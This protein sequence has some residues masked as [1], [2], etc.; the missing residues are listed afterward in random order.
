MAGLVSSA[1]GPTICVELR[2]SDRLPLAKADRNQ[3]E[4]A[5]LNLAVNA[6]DAMDGSG[7]LTISAAANPVEP[8]HPAGLRPGLYIRLCVSD[9][10]KGM[11]E[12]TRIRAVEPFFST[13]GVGKGTGLGLSMAYGLASQLGGALTIESE[14]GAGAHVAIWLPQS[15]E[16]LASDDSCHTRGDSKDETGVV[17]LVDDDTQSRTVIAEMLT[18]LGFQVH[19][20]SAPEAALSAIRA[21][22]NPDILVTD[23]L[24]PGM[25]GLELASTV[26]AIIPDA[27]TLVI[28]GFAEVESIDASEHWLAK[29]FVQRDLA[30]ALAAIRT[31]PKAAH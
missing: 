17:L 6:R 30:K 10:G 15:V 28:S 21:G 9:T 23:H 24:M 13:K 11:D 19:Q 29:P 3:L 12:A 2:I 8:E 14:P 27:H 1:V 22:L 16:P 7:Q 26:R 5:I 18:E 20:A 4:M 31:S 25:T